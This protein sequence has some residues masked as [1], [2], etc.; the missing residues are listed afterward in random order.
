MLFGASRQAGKVQPAD[1]AVGVM[2]LFRTDSMS[3]SAVCNEGAAP[4]ASFAGAGGDAPLAMTA[5][6][7]VRFRFASEGDVGAGGRDGGVRSPLVVVDMV[8]G[9]PVRDGA[10]RG[11][12]QHAE[13]RRRGWWVARGKPQHNAAV[14]QVRKV[15]SGWVFAEPWARQELGAG[16]RRVNGLSR[17][18]FAE[19]RRG[20]NAAAKKYARRLNYTSCRHSAV[21]TCKFSNAVAFAVTRKLQHRADR[22]LQ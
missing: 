11:S 12:V 22:V 21:H 20:W 3:S 16:G 19:R 14:C 5:S 10:M 1:S 7:S 6:V 15:R 18:G 4:L 17:G 8:M 2:Y 9:T 13:D